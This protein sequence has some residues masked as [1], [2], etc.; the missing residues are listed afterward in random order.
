MVGFDSDLEKIDSFIS[1][2]SKEANSNKARVCLVT[3]DP[4]VGKTAILR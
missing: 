3:G 4:G 2:G 1:Q